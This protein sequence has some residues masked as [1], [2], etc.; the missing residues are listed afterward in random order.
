MPSNSFGSYLIK[1]FYFI[2]TKWKKGYKIHQFVFIQT[3]TWSWCIKNLIIL[4]GIVRGNVLVY[5]YGSILHNNP[6]EFKK[7]NTTYF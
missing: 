5:I 2:F 4:I 7:H 1:R 3:H 6:F